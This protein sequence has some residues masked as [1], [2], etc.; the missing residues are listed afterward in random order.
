MNDYQGL[1]GTKGQA[2]RGG[3]KRKNRDERKDARRASALA[4]QAAY[5][6][7]TP[8]QKIKQ[9]LAFNGNIGPKQRRKLVAEVTEKGQS[10]MQELLDKLEDME[11]AEVL[12]LAKNTLP[13]S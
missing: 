10:Q 1:K 13:T 3:G 9:A 2:R 5:D 4:R 6:A 8:E 7:L 11:K 12:E